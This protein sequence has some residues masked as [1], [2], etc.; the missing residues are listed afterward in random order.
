MIH[1]VKIQIYLQ[2]LNFYCFIF[3]ILGQGQT[4]GNLDAPSS[5]AMNG[6][7]QAKF[8]R[9]TSVKSKTLNPKWH[10]RFRLYVTHPHCGALAHMPP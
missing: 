4:N 8:I 3:F 10:E 2:Y 1:Q 5:P 7:M 6:P 9:A